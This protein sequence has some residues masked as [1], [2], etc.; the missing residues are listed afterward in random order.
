MA[1]VYHWIVALYR[2]VLLGLVIGILI[3]SVI[4][5]GNTETAANEAETA[6]T[7]ARNAA[8]AAKD[9]SNT[10]VNYLE[11]IAKVFISPPDQTKSIE[12]QIDDISKALDECKIKIGREVV[13]RQ[14]PSTQQSD[15]SSNSQT[16]T[17]QTKKDNPKKSPS[18]N[19]TPP[20]DC[21]L[22]LPGCVD[23]PLL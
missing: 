7:E 9:G 5:Q 6:A 13:T 15:Q 22:G 21:D 3:S 14:A 11:C 12:G 17:E 2:P 20:P 1:R 10:A 23:L 16:P 18:D 19:N 4:S 8:Q